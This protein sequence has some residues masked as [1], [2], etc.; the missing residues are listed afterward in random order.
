MKMPKRSLLSL[1][2]LAVIGVGIALVGKALGGQSSGSPIHL[3]NWFSG[4][5]NFSLS[6]PAAPEAPAAPT[7]PSLTA[8]GEGAAVPVESIRSLEVELGAALVTIQPGDGFSVTAD[9]MSAIDVYQDEDTFQ[10]TANDRWRGNWKE[11]HVDITV[12]PDYL[13]DELDLTIG[14]GR[15]TAEGLRC[16]EADLCV[17]AGQMVLTD[18]SATASADLEA[19]A[20]QIKLDGEVYGQVEISAEAGQVVLNIPEPEDY[21]YEVECRLGNVKMGAYSFSG[22]STVASDSTSAANLFEIECS[23]GSVEVNFV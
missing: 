21:G 22:M 1:L 5:T 11:F 13:L 19:A 20:G 23:V 12:P 6:A 10:V 3:G 17:G 4:G 8:A 16:L 18:F 15:M 2:A 14:A 9:D 7:A